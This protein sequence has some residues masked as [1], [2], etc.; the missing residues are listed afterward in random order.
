MYIR[1][2]GAAALAGSAVWWWHR[3]QVDR[4]LAGERLDR[5]LERA[6]HRWVRAELDAALVLAA[7]TDVIN[8]AHIAREE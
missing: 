5:V 1:C 2:L 8:R 4:I 6:Q 7:A 3:K